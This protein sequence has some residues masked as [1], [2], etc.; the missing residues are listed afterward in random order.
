[1]N[2]ELDKWDH[3]W[4]GL[5]KE[6]GDQ[7]ASCPSIYSFVDPQLNAEYEVDRLCRY[8]E[9]ARVIATTSRR[10]FPCVITGERFGGSLSSRTDGIW[11]WY[12]DLSHYIREHGLVIP[13][14]MLK[15]IE[16]N[17]YNPPPV[18]DRD[19]EKLE[20]PLL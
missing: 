14:K 2:L 16:K 5:W 11:L 10:N 15:H 19:I 8:L 1:M 20:R 9:T 3:R 4:F 7:Y 6:L 17:S 13:N 12:D 18:T